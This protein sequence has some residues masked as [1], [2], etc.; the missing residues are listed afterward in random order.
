MAEVKEGAK[1][2]DAVM[3]VNGREAV[4][5]AIYKEGD[6]NTVAVAA[7]VR[8]ALRR[9]QPDLGDEMQTTV[10]YDQSTFIESAID[11]V[12]QAALQGAVLAVAVLLLFLRSI[13][14]TLIVALTIPASVLVT[15]GL[16]RYFDL[17]LNVMSLGVS[18]SRLACSWITRSLCLKTL[19]DAEREVIRY[20]S[21]LQKAAVKYPAPCL[22]RR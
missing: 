15:F 22:P 5:I 2:R 13:R 20:V 7:N 14:A 10:I 11:E 1:D 19:L 21:R 6:G 17:S 3:R 12:R 18:R 16:M 8:E 4:E 9:L